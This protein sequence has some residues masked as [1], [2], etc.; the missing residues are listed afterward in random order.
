MALGNSS[1]D[2][3]Q[4][5]RKTGTRKTTAPAPSTR[6]AAPRS[7][8]AALPY[9]GFLV[10]CCLATFLAGARW[11]GAALA[12]LDS[13]D[14]VVRRDARLD[15]AQNPSI[16]L[17]GSSTAALS[18]F[19]GGGGGSGVDGGAATFS[20]G[21]AP[22]GPVT[23]PPRVPPSHV[24]NTRPPSTMAVRPMSEE[25]RNFCDNVN[26]ARQSTMRQLGA[27]AQAAQAVLATVCRGEARV[28]ADDG[29]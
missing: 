28:A 23:A 18:S 7:Y 16:V 8:C 20:R 12:S 6:A 10:A 9:V 25:A 19:R 17:G 26:T 11:K 22:G 24:N 2:T 3:T 15:A 13:L 14:P 29:V 1:K 4:L 21:A 27:A 5:S